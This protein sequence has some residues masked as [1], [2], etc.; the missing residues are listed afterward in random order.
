RCEVNLDNKGYHL[1][2]FPVP[3]GYDAESY[4]RA[5]V[6]KGVVERYGAERASGDQELRERV[7]RELG[8]IHNMGFDT[9]FL[10]VWDIC[11]Y[12]A[13]NDIW[14]NVRGSGAG[15][16][17]AYTL[18]ITNIDPI[19]NDLIFERFLNPARVSMPDIDIDFPDDRRAEMI[20]YAS[21][22]YGS[23]KVAAII[24]FGTLGAR[25]AVR[26]VARALDMP[27][28][29][30]DRI[31]RMIPAVPGK[32]VHLDKLLFD[33]GTAEE[34]PLQAQEVREVYQADPTA[35]EVLDTAIKLEG[36]ARHASTHA[37]GIVIADKPI[38]EY[39]PLHRP[40]KHEVGGPVAQVTQFPMAVIEEI[41]LLKVDFL[42]LAT[43]TIMRKACEFVEQRHGRRLDL[44]TIPYE[45]CHD[46]PVAD[47][48]VRK[49]YELLQQ[50][51]TVGVFQVEGA[52]MKRVLTEMKPSEFEH[53]IAVISLFRPGPMEYI[54]TYIARMHGKEPAAYH[55]PAL[56]PILE[57]TYGILVYQE[58]IMR[59]A[60]ELGGYSPGEADLMRRAVSKKKAKDIEYHKGIFV[61]GACERG[62]PQEAAERIYGD[63]EFFARY[64]F[65]KCL[66]GDVE[67]VDAASGR[68]VKIEDLY[69]GAATITETVTCAIEEL[70]LRGGTV[71][72]VMNNGVK[73]VFRLTTALGHT[74]EATANHPFY[75]FD[76]WRLL[77][78]L[79]VGS[80][81]AVPRRLPVEGNVEWP[82][83]EV[84][85]LGHLLAEGT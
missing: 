82:E 21:S 22:K 12:A 9:Y 58:Q 60:S 6:Q 4:L 29:E 77:E 76:G 63:I 23:D 65:N 39:C 71:S 44:S 31:A 81:L 16:V 55:H 69:T 14:W 67:I 30:A 73:P 50:G 53:I 1:P 72:T 83:H 19:K 62:I 66:P 15:S 34:W 46:D 13:E 5:L 27:L 75:T 51:H 64:G 59:V 43:L 52:G 37:A 84:I 32:P 11:R 18:R 54:P 28:S 8:I 20:Q 57:N 48:D 3:E 2:N 47:A 26:D 41:G 40:T 85:A 70:N 45:R 17:V 35:R 78:E 79:Q 61:K 42:G 10:I 38:V 56:K 36:L 25:A 74:I 7:E 33:Q 49:A 80:Q 68:L 24:T